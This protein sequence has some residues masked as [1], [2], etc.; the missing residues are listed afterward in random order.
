MAKSDNVFEHHAVQVDNIIY[1]VHAHFFACWPQALAAAASSWFL[2]CHLSLTR[3]LDAIRLFG[4]TKGT[5]WQITQTFLVPFLR[6]GIMSRKIILFFYAVANYPTRLYDKV[7]SIGRLDVWPDL[8]KH[9]FLFCY[10]VWQCGDDTPP[11]DIFRL[12]PVRDALK[13]KFSTQ[14]FFWW[15]SFEWCYTCWKKKSFWCSSRRR[16][17]NS[18]IHKKS[19]NCQNN[20]RSRP[21]SV[22]PTL[23]RGLKYY[24]NKSAIVR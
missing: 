19:N 18:S 6:V 11:A 24:A 12:L 23:H 5:P 21:Q 10:I 17:R 2:D 13:R 16:R 20:V 7:K 1:N 9:N 14:I 8:N 4:G 15:M 22:F 3:S